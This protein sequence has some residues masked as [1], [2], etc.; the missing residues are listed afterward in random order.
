MSP[1]LQS[2]LL[3]VLQDGEV[4]RVGESSSLKVDVRTVAATNRDIEKE[5]AEKRFRQDLFYR[6][7][8]VMLRVPS[9]GAKVNSRWLS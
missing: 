6:L 7:N 3:C 8:V 5:V 4:R 1:Q 9:I 2:K